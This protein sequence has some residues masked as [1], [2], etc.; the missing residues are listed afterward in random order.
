MQQLLWA[1]ADHLSNNQAILFISV[2][3][4][5]LANKEGDPFFNETIWAMKV[6]FLKY[7]KN[8][9]PVFLLLSHPTVLDTKFKSEGV[10]A[11]YGY[12]GIGEEV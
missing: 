9:P 1:A 7:H 3:L 10:K 5:Q 4:V 12:L 11:Y 6:K 2:I 8:I